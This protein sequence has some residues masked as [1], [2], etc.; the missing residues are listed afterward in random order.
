MNL[1]SYAETLNNL[2][3]PLQ[4]NKFNKLINKS[5]NLITMQSNEAWEIMIANRPESLM[6]YRI[7]LRN[8]CAQTFIDESSRFLNRREKI[9]SVGVIFV[10]LNLIY[11]RIKFRIARQCRHKTT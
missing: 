9:N 10:Q 6:I 2:K 4:D 1:P 8:Q 5:L 7:S 11:L 3:Y